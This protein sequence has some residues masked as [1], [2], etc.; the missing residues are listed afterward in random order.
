MIDIDIAKWSDNALVEEYLLT[1]N[2]GYFDELY[3]RYSNK[4]Y[5]K[6]YS[7]LGD[8]VSA[9]D[10]TQDI[11]LKLILNLSKFSQ[12]S[13]FSTW[14]YSITYNYCVDEI[15]R[16][17]KNK[18]IFDEEGQNLTEI[19]DEE[20]DPLTSEANL[21]AMQATFDVIDEA[22][23]TILLMKYQDN[24]MVKEIAEILNLSESAVKMRLKR[25]KEKFQ[26]IFMDILRI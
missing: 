5:Y 9:E 11:F 17:K 26:K 3:K 21:V 10:A 7:L 20:D 24:M 16:L 12:K 1:Q 23:R 13:K 15:R 14:I 22:D 19:A 8:Y 6:C 18:M 2:I 25:A 4:I